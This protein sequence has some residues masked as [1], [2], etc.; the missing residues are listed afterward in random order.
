MGHLAAGTGVGR[1]RGWNAEMTDA[2]DHRNNSDISI[3]Q[4]VK[5]RVVELGRSLDPRDPIYLD[6]NY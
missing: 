6:T 4:H 5:S 1:Q 2:R 3:D